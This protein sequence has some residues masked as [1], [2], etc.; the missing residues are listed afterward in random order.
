[1]TKAQLLEYTPIF[2]ARITLW[3]WYCLK[4][5][6]ED[7]NEYQGLGKLVYRWII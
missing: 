7:L 3:Q 6:N 2:Y 4:A 5:F 1:M